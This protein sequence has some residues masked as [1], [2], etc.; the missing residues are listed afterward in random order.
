M[1]RFSCI[2]LFIFFAMQVVYSQLKTFSFFYLPTSE[3]PKYRKLKGLPVKIDDNSAIYIHGKLIFE[4]T[5]ILLPG[6][7]FS[8]SPIFLFHFLI[9]VIDISK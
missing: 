7:K 9:Q 1:R 4:P 3:Q 8:I 5:G 2:F 6:M